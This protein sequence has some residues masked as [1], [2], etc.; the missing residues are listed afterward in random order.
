MKGSS[1]ARAVKSDGVAWTWH[2][3]VV[4]EIVVGSVGVGNDIEAC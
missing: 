4:E 1:E 2:D 3:Q